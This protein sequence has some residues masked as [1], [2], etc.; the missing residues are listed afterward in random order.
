MKN[1]KSLFVL[2]FVLGLLFAITSVSASNEKGSAKQRLGSGSRFITVGSSDTIFSSTDGAAESWSPDGIGNQSLS[3]T[4]IAYG[5]GRLIT[6]A[7]NGSAWLSTDGKKGNWQDANLQMKANPNINTKRLTSI[8]YGN[9]CFMAAGYTAGKN[10]DLAVFFQLKDGKKAW[11]SAQ[12]AGQYNLNGITA[13]RNSFVAVGENR[14]TASA[15]IFIMDPDL[16]KI[17]PL[18]LKGVNPFNAVAYGN[19]TYMAVGLKGQVY[20]WG[21]AKHRAVKYILD[22]V[23]NLLGVTYANK[24]FVTVG[25]GGKIFY[26]ENGAA[27]TSWKT[28]T[29]PE[30]FCFYKIAYG[31]GRF[32]VVGLDSNSKAGA[33]WSEDLTQWHKAALESNFLSAIVFKP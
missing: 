27:K 20:L 13:G 22:G 23:S 5:K 19:G 9:N 16:R 32:V 28:V 17:K 10:A 25:Y 30:V 21:N 1:Q 6:T 2:F 29:V 14:L 4:G 18:S 31:N 15:Q 3:L 26:S 12:I 7:I 33:W 24:R 8:A 11:S